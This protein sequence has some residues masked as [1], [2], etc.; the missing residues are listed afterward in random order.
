MV[1]CYH[2]SMR[3]DG[4]TSVCEATMKVRVRTGVLRTRW[5]KATAR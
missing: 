4:M 5:R 3:R 2:V 1:E